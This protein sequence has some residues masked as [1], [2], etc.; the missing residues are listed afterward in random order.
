MICHYLA[1]KSTI[2]NFLYI[3]EDPALLYPHPHGPYL[4]ISETNSGRE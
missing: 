2:L 3:P 4:T 1:T